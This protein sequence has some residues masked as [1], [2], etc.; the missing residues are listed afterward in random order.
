MTKTKS[1]VKILTKKVVMCGI[2][3]ALALI[4]SLIESYIPPIIP[5]LP[6]A[7]IGI[8]NVILLACFLLVGWKEGYIVLLLRCVLNAVFAGNM[9]MLLWSL[10]SALVAYTIMLLLSKAKIFSITGISIVGGGVHNAMQ[11]FVA[12]AIVGRAVF[13]YLPYMLLAGFLCGFATGIVCYFC[14]KIL[15]CSKHN[16]VY[17]RERTQDI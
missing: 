11:I 15:S 17:E 8:G 6:Y 13:A 5:I 12:S 10:P 16:Y 1:N 9:S 3:L 2:F 7:K 14:V 4:V